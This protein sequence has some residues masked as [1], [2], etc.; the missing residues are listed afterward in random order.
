MESRTIS[1]R[2]FFLGICPALGRGVSDDGHLGLLSKTVQETLF[3]VKRKDYGTPF[4][5]LSLI[6]HIFLQS[7]HGMNFPVRRNGIIFAIAIKNNCNVW[8]KLG[9][10]HHHGQVEDFPKQFFLPGT[11]TFVNSRRCSRFNSRYSPEAKSPYH[12]PNVKFLMAATKSM[13]RYL[14]LKKFSTGPIEKLKV[15]QRDSST[16]TYKGPVYM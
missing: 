13:A 3:I 12:C 9:T 15:R 4:L 1:R 16:K 14:T 2:A 10:C 8:R 6:L 11:R 5:S 7:R